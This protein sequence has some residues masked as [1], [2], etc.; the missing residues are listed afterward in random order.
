MP[1]VRPPLLII[2]ALILALYFAWAL[3]RTVP[4]PAFLTVR[5]VEYLR[6][7]NHLGPGVVVYINRTGRGGGEP[8]PY[9]IVRSLTN[10][11]VFL[12]PYTGTAIPFERH[13]LSSPTFLVRR[14]GL[15]RDQ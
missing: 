10:L 14:E 8:E 9:G 12:D 15:K 7:E 11:E 6:A 2:S 3:W 13:A 4:E 5:G 1:T